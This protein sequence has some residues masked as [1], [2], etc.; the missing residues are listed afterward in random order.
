MSSCRCHSTKSRPLPDRSA[1]SATQSR[2]GL[3]EERLQPDRFAVS[4]PVGGVG[5]LREGRKRGVK[6]KAVVELQGPCLG[7]LLFTTQPRA[8]W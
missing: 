1:R 8:E 5:R 3:A 7:E 4:D 2:S 6:P